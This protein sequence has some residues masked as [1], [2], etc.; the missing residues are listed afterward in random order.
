[1]DKNNKRLRGS[2]PALVFL[3]HA[4]QRVRELVSAKRGTWL[5]ID[6]EGWERDHTVIT[7]MGYSILKWDEQ[8]NEKR[9]CGHWIVKEGEKYRNGTFVPDFR[10]VSWH[11]SRLLFLLKE[12]HAEREMP[13]LAL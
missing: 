4:F 12:C 3:C 5:A 2:N 1:L 11:T 8:G 6:F 9:E 10:Y 7:E 13:R